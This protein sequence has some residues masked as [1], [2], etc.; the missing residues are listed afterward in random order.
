M[1]ESMIWVKFMMKCNRNY[2]SSDSDTTDSTV[3]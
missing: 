2:S 1:N 3:E